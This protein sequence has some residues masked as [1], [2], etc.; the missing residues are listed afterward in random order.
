MQRRGFFVGLDKIREAH[1][2]KLG[3]DLPHLRL[4]LSGSQVEEKGSGESAEDAE[5]TSARCTRAREAR[6]EALLQRGF[7]TSRYAIAVP[8]LPRSIM[9]HHR[10]GLLSSSFIRFLSYG[11]EICGETGPLCLGMV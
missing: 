8:C 11:C 6:V 10:S 2:C 9:H 1:G 7:F 4:R 5:L 3:H